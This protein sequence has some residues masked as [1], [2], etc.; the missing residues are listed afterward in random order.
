MKHVKLFESFINEA[1]I[2]SIKDVKAAVKYWKSHASPRV[3]NN[4]IWSKYQIFS[5]PIIVSGSEIG[6]KA[7]EVLLLGIYKYAG[8]NRVQYAAVDDTGRVSA[9]NGIDVT[10]AEFDSIAKK[11]GKDLHLNY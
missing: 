6:K 7:S 3:L 5:K 1:K 11:Y 2:P 10:D 8:K 4:M 9:G